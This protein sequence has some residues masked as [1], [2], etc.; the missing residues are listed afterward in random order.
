MLRKVDRSGVK[1][2]NPTGKRKSIHRL[3]VGLRRTHRTNWFTGVRELDILKVGI[4]P[5]LLLN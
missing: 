2:L 3:R 1:L 5:Q 4:T